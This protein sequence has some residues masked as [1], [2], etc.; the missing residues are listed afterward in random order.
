MTPTSY[1]VQSS[2]WYYHQSQSRMKQLLE[3]STNGVSSSAPSGPNTGDFWTDTS[4]DPPILK[5]WNGSSWIEVGSAGGAGASFPVI[6]T[7]SLSEDNTSGSSLY[8]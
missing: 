1:V 7:V 6:S 2:G 5:S 3:V 4:S 8:Q